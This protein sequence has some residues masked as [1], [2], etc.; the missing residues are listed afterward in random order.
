MPPEEPKRPPEEVPGR[1]EEAPEE[2]PTHLVIDSTGLKVYG[3][4]E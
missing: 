2:A 4:G 1:A 3:E